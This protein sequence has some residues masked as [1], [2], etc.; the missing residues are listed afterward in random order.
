MFDPSQIRQ[1]FLASLRNHERADR[2]Y[3]HW[4][5]TSCLPDGVADALTSLPFQP[6]GIDDT[7][8]RRETH[9]DTRIHFGEQNRR[10]HPVIEAVS[11]AF[12][13]QTTVDALKVL[14][15]APIAGTSLR[16]EY[17]QDSGNFW[18]EPHTDIG[19]K[20]FTMLI[21][22]NREPEAVDWG[23]D[24]YSDP[25]THVGRAPAGFNHGLIFVP[26]DDTWHGFDLRPLTG[27]RKTII[28]NYVAPEWRNRQELCFP[29]HP[30]A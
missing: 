22:L 8:G 28:V 12:Q 26:G 16:I 23:T 3:P 7:R 25:H 24:L 11:V 13:D 10:R 6:A 20:K 5:L 2:P 14:T 1:A 30:V 21:Y 4:F 27:I 17:C 19:V 9:N 29:N 15:G 18:L